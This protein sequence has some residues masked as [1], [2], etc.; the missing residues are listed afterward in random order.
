MKA[1][2]GLRAAAG[3]LAAAAFGAAALAGAAAFFAAGLA[4]A[5][6]F[7][8][9]FL[10]GAAVDFLAVAIFEPPKRTHWKNAQL[11]ARAYIGVVLLFVQVFFEIFSSKQPSGGETGCSRV[12]KREKKPWKSA[13]HGLLYMRTGGN[14]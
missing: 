6:G 2:F 13:F 9:A 14:D 8:A 3:F 7:A 4:A 1:A 12:R 10:A 5:A 11:I